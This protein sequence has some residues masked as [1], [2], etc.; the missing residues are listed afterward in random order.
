MST[1][2]MQRIGFH[3]QSDVQLVNRLVWGGWNLEQYTFD[4]E[5]FFHPLVG[6]LI[7]NLNAATGDPIAALLDPVTLGNLDQA[8]FDAQYAAGDP[9]VAITSYDQSI[10]LD[11]D[12]P[13]ANYNWELL[14]HIPV[15]VA[16][17]LSQN[18]RFAEAQKWFHYV[19]DPT[20]T[21]L[22][23][24]TATRC[25]KFL[26]FRNNPAS[27]D[28]AALLGLLSA[29][30]PSDPTQAREQ[31]SILTSYHASVME[32]F[33]PFA[34]ARPRPVAFQYYVVMK[35]LDNLIAWGD[36]LFGQMTIE[37]VNEA[38]LCYV[39]AANLLGP[40]P[41]PVPA[42]GTTTA[43]CYNDLRGG[44]DALGDALVDLEAQF[45]FNIT[46][47]VPVGPVSGAGP[48][49]GIGRSLY[50]CIPQ[51]AKLL[52]YWDVVEDRLTKIRSCE[53][54]AGQVQ[55]MPLFDPPID[56]GMLVRATAAGLDLAGVISGLNQPVSVVRSPIVIQ[57][58][59][60]LCMEVRSLGT[61]LLAATEKGDSEALAALRQTH[62]ISLQA[63]AQSMRYL[64]WQQAKASTD[65]LVRG[66]ASAYE[67]Y[68]FYLRLLGQQPDGTAT[69]ATLDVSHDTVITE[70]NFDDAYQA[71]V[72]QFDTPISHQRY[73]AA[74][75]RAGRLAL[76]AV[77]GVWRRGLV[78]E[79]QRGCRA[80]RPPAGGPRGTA[81]LG[82]DRHGRERPGHDPELRR[83]P[84]LLGHGR[85][86]DGLR[87]RQAV[88]RL[89]DRC[90]YPA[91]D[92]GLRG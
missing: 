69:P 70:D 2:A 3:G 91:H 9:D 1:I 71:L 82:C 74:P 31:Q 50:F 40:R 58:A 35:Y 67:R 20:S 5:N 63:L 88:G 60:E 43:K 14:Y 17:H 24:P 72:G 29:P 86:L 38:T 28:L 33:E 75:A 46:T 23:L 85:A 64:Q 59:L 11:N 51:N 90:R 66:R 79:Q 84:A 47:Q 37:T 87:R 6:K 78:P 56:P 4:F 65:A 53:N 10:E 7:S 13:Y 62:E 61:A 39:L 34:V 73:P 81:C 52:A 77:W 36:S 54:L 32:P 18:Q 44:L 26:Y 83:R 57:K 15:A 89:E 68:S 92:G 22:N 48:L 21:E 16:V 42:I 8:F 55:L 45:P 27:L 25:W 76:D 19:F 80:E 12:R 30:T 49:L 41:Q